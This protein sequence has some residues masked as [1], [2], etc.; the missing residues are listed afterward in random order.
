M[1]DFLH[2]HLFQL[3]LYMFIISRITTTTTTNHH[4][5]FTWCERRLGGTWYKKISR[6]SL[7]RPFLQTG[8]KVSIINQ[9]KLIV[10]LEPFRHITEINILIYYMFE[11]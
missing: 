8:A 2:I 5:N 9:V 3:C 4:G 1:H 10:C 11:S 6:Q 7:S